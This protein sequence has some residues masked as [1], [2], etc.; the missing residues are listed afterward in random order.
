MIRS[1]A[2]L[3]L[4]NLSGDAAQDYFADGMTDELITNLGQIGSIRVISRTSIMQYKGVHKPLPQ[5]AREPDVD[6]VVEGTVLPSGGQVRITAQLIQA[7]TDQHLWTNSYQG[8]IRD[9]LGLQSEVASAIASEILT[10]LT[11]PTE[12][13]P[14]EFAGR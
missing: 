1:I 8:D 6:A 10:K 14:E 2:V 13:R 5:I 11:P 7:R 4:E 9:V 3:P 12:G